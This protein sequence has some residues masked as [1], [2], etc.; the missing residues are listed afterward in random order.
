MKLESNELWKLTT[1]ITEECYELLG[2][3]PEEEKWGMQAKMRARAFEAGND[4][5]ESVGSIDPRDVK[6]HLGL[7]RRDLFGLKNTVRLAFNTGYLDVS[8]DLIVKIDKAIAL[9]D[10]EIQKAT[11]DIPNWYQEMDPPIKRGAK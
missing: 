8:P 5:A 11:K 3:L 2:N 7:A 4:V 10:K 6:W 1:Q 9:V